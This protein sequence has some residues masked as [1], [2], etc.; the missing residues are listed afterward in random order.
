MLN[1]RTL[2]INAFVALMSLLALTTYQGLSFAQAQPSSNDSIDKNWVIQ[3][4]ILGL[5]TCHGIPSLAGLNASKL[6]ELPLLT[7]HVNDSAGLLTAAENNLLDAY[8]Y[9]Y[10]QKAGSQLAV[11]I[12]PT[13]NGEGIFSQAQRIACKYRLGR[14]NLGDGVFL[15]VSQQERKFYLYVMAAVSPLISDEKAQEIGRTILT[16]AFKSQKY[17]EGITQTMASVILLIDGHFVAPPRR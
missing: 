9:D 5:D 14:K 1:S 13:L 11:F 16:P 17:Y 6:P 15:L 4:H 8:L 3:Q 2:R 12:V 7:H 10:E